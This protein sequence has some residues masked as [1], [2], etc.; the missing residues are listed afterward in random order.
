M[1]YEPA[2]Q[3]L[4]MALLLAGSRAGL[5]IDE[6][7][8][9]LRISRRTAERMRD[10][11]AEV[12]SG[13]EHVDGD[14]RIRRWRLPTNSPTPVAAPRPEA[15]AVLESIAR[16]C[17]SRGEPDRA[18]LLREAA[19]C[20]LARLRPEVLCRVEP[21]IEAL[22]EAEGIA[23]R[24]GPR[25]ALPS[26]LVRSLRQAI[27]APQMVELSYRQPSEPPFR[28]VVC[29]YGVLRGGRGWLVAHTESNPDM[30]LWRLDRIQVA[31]V[32][33]QGFD[34]REFDLRTYAQQSFGVFQEAPIDV[35]LRIAPAAAEAAEGWVFHPS[36]T[37]TA[38]PDGALT[39]RLRAGGER[40]MCW[41]FFT[42]GKAL[43]IL[44]PNSLRQAMARMAQQA[45]AHHG[46]APDGGQDA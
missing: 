32:L 8:G 6:L 3:L 46:I 9:S 2:Q 20:L 36:Q 27:A 30:R 45:A 13:L 17:D 43:T 39:V 11:V 31:T 26:G 33:D 5:S 41:H 38:E 4:R 28:T 10:A 34:R 1:R 22:M 7:A 37:V 23:M 18:A 14:D 40:E 44:A 35:V 29:P 12:F 42:W 16:D 21:D 15:V 25:A 19:S 24:P